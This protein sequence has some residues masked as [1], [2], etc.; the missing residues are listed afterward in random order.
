VEL[1]CGDEGLEIRS[2]TQDEAEAWW[3]SIRP[4]PVSVVSPDWEETEIVG[5]LEVP[6]S[7]PEER[8][9]AVAAYGSKGANLAALYQRID[10]SLQLQGFLVPMSASARDEGEIVQELSDRIDDDFGPETMVRFRSSSNAEDALGF[11]GAGLYESESVCAADS[12]DA[13]DEGPSVCDPDKGSERTI[14]EGLHTVW[15]SLWTERAVE[16]RA[17]YGIDE[18]EVAMAVLVNERSKDEQANIVAFSGIPGSGDDPRYLVEAQVGWLDVVANE[19]GT[20]PERVLLSPDGTV[21]RVQSSSEVDEVLDD[22][23]YGEIAMHLTEIVDVFPIDGEAD[24][25]ILLDTEWKVLEDGRLII[26]Q[27]RPFVD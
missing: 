23:T 20:W 24:G 1:C 14:E 2:A 12:W 10:L 27:V 7:T 26:K 9:A 19:S 16:E 25:R 3:A 8:Q 6:T 13:D 5:L 11:S 4:D 18:T 15:D 21:E 17:W 22:A